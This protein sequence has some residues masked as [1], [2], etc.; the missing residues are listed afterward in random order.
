MVGEPTPWPT[1]DPNDTNAAGE[2]LDNPAENESNTL[3]D[4]QINQ[5]DQ[6]DPT[7]VDQ[8][9]PNQPYHDTDSGNG[10]GF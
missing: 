10:P 1:P 3:S 2:N 9:T 7:K 6:T 5:D 8:P 4:E